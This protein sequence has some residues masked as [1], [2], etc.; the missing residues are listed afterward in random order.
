[1]V[2]APSDSPLFIRAKKNG[3]R[4]YPLSFNLLAR[5]G[6]YDQLKK[7]FAAETPFA[8][9]CHGRED[10]RIVLKAAWQTGVPCRILSQ[11]T[12]NEIKKIWLS[13][14]KY[15]QYCHYTF[16]D[17]PQTIPLLQKKFN[18]HDIRIFCIPQGIIAPQELLCNADARKKISSKLGLPPATRFMGLTGRM[19]LPMM[20]ERISQLFNTIQ[21][22]PSHHMVCISTDAQPFPEEFKTDMS[23]LAKGR[24][25]FMDIDEDAWSLYRA[26]DCMVVL[27]ESDPN[28]TSCGLSRH[29]LEIMYAKCPVIASHDFEVTHFINRTLGMPQDYSGQDKPIEQMI[30]DAISTEE[31]R[32][33]ERT[34]A[35]GEY[36]K[37]HHTIDTMG[38]DI[39]RIYRLRQVRQEQ[40]HRR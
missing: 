40:R 18:I 35:I 1:M 8:V 16:T 24:I 4:V 34:A 7:L 37:Q 15:N 33:L 9:N 3:Y 39:L 22:Q 30:R 27:S 28:Q 26:L 10:A 5:F 36:I 38:R 20:G 31:S 12:D 21:S 2:I 19:P 25:H 29:L 17:S 13:K 32:Q 11:H 23:R 14:R 6:E